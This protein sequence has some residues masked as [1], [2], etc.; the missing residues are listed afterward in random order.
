MQII[1]NDGILAFK[2]DD[3]CSPLT[4]REKAIVE[5]LL[6]TRSHVSEVEKIHRIKRYFDCTVSEAID[7]YKVTNINIGNIG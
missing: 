1:I 5:Y 3:V 4:E 2:S 6:N 7:V